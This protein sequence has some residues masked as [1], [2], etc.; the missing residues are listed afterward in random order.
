MQCKLSCNKIS[1]NQK[2]YARQ[3]EFQGYIFQRN[4]DY[5]SRVQNLKSVLLDENDVDELLF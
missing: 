5:K 3:R 4:H 1:R 2:G